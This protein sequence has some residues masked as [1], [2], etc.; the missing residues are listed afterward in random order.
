MSG[1]VAY[2]TKSEELDV[3]SFST[4]IFG[5]WADPIILLMLAS[6]VKIKLEMIFLENYQNINW[7]GCSGA[8]MS[9]SASTV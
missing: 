3:S 8:K 6:C 9:S 2:P 5:I 4:T 1:S 7:L